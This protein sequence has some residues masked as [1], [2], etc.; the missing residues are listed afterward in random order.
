MGAVARSALGYWNA[1]AR[2]DKALVDEMATLISPHE[3][4]Q[5]PAWLPLAATSH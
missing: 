5:T 2:T 4:R 3:L 1:E